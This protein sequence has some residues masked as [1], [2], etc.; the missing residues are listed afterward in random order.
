MYLNSMLTWTYLY[1]FLAVRSQ[2]FAT[3]AVQYITE[4]ENEVTVY[5]LHSG[6]LD[7]H[8]FQRITAPL[9]ASY[10]KKKKTG[11]ALCGWDTRVESRL[12][13]FFHFN[14]KFGDPFVLI[15]KSPQLFASP[16]SQ[17][18]QV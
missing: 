1:K 15:K 18:K 7:W 13:L 8:I 14:F 9:I 5:Q 17:F 16:V 6:T 10:N 4:M 11:Q 2:I 12:T 3:H